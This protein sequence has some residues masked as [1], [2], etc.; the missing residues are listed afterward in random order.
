M[1]NELKL[2]STPRHKENPF[3]E[4]AVDEVDKRTVYRQRYGHRADQK[5]IVS[6]VDKETGEVFLTSFLRRIEVDE[7][8]FAK[9][10]L[11]Q[12]TTLNDLSTAGIRVLTYI[13]TKMKPNVTEILLNREECMEVSKYKSLKP[14]YK[15]LAELVAANIIARGWT[16][17]LYFINPLIIF[18]G[19]RVVFAT[20]YI[21]KKNPNL[22][23]RTL[24]H[25]SEARLQMHKKETTSEVEKENIE[26]YGTA[27]PTLEDV[28]DA[29]TFTP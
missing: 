27:Y 25:L 19:N 14:I 20:E 22:K 10:Y 15:G 8:E 26:R 2:T 12:I 1:E 24:H 21:K 16:D 3:L 6:T 13:M 7:A 29:E 28:C 5:A 23:G 18:N 4:K 9:I 17:N 11:S